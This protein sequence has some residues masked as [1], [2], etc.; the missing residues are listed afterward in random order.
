MKSANKVILNTVFLYSKML[1]SM[2]LSLYTTR[3]VL[4]ALGA[5]DFGIFSLV[6]GVIVMFSFLNLSMSVSTHRYLSF[7]VDSKNE[8]KL[9]DIFKTSVILHLIIGLAIVIVLEL[10]RVFLFDGFLNIPPDRI[11]IAIM[12]FHLMVI[13]AFFTIN[14][15]P[16][17]ALINAHE[18]MLFD[19]ILGVF[20]SIL[21][22]GIAIWLIYYDNDRLLF[23]SFLIAVL[24]ILI[25]LL[26][27]AYCYRNYPE[28]KVN[29]TKKI[30][31]RLFWDMTSFASWNM[32][33]SLAS[34]GRNQGIAIILNLFFGAII[35]TAFGIA[36]QVSNQLSSFSSMMLKAVVPQIM[37]SEGNNDR[38]RMLRLSMISS[39]FSFFFDGNFCHSLYF[40]NE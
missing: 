38:T 20:E 16:Y 14:S 11:H 5:T 26:K 17:D 32:F 13:S 27:S 15:V 2:L 35:N 28:C 36:N 6:G 7:H 40:R 34:M 8:N 29:L 25:R 39:K 24:T 30:N 31:K 22:L 9:K 19:S 21:K 10:S 23:Y 18:N 12:V 3:L 4:N 33:G 37:K 1:I